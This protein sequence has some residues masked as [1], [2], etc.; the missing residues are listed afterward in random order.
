[1]RSVLDRR[2]LIVVR[3]GAGRDRVAADI[4]LGAT[5]S[6]T[7]IGELRMALCAFEGLR[8]RCVGPDERDEPAAVRAILGDGPR[9]RT[10]R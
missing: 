1:L 2:P 3:F 5:E 9:A 7:S 6:V 10:L 4:R 8:D